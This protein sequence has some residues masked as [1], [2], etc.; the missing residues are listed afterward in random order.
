[1]KILFINACVR[2]NSRTLLLARHLLNKLSGDVTEVN[3][4]RENIQALNAESLNYRESRLHAGESDDPIFRY[5]RQFADA[6]TIVIA[7][8]FWDLSFPS[9]LK[10]YIEAITVSGITFTYVDN[11]PKGL[12]RAKKLY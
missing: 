9:S 8:P 5:A 3:L 7:A 11:I 6:D 4:E 2:E 1:M 12:C 10:N